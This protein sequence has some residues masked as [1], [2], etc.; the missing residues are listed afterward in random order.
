MIINPYI[1]IEK[2]SCAYYIVNSHCDYDIGDTHVPFSKSPEWNLGLRGLL[3]KES[4]MKHQVPLQVLVPT[5]FSSSPG[6]RGF[7][8]A[9]SSGEE[10]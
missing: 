4:F 2:L 7:S 5:E 10:A 1:L 8:Q 3:R 9:E 6:A